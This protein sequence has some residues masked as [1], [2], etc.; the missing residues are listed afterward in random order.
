[1]LRTLRADV[2]SIAWTLNYI[3]FLDLF[4][5]FRDSL[6]L[7]PQSNENYRGNNGHSIEIGQTSST[8]TSRLLMLPLSS[9]IMPSVS[10]QILDR[11][12]ILKPFTNTW[13]QLGWSK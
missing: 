6:P 4:T 5:F 3:P 11:L 8:L 10:T 1:M 12:S 9:D 13:S 2:L 7:L